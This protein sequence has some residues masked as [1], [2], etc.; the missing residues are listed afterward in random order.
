MILYSKIQKQDLD[1]IDNNLELFKKYN[2]FFKKDDYDTVM[3]MYFESIF[4]LLN[5]ISN[6]YETS[7]PNI[8][9]KWDNI[10]WKDRST[11]LN[12]EWDTH[13]EHDDLIKY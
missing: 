13:P 8:S 6:Q 9:S 11:A 1:E 10:K 3:K 12:R 5:E 7:E 2:K 4:Y